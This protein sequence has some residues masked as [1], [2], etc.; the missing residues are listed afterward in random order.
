MCGVNVRPPVTPTPPPA[1]PPPSTPPPDQ[2]RPAPPVAAQPPAQPPVVAQPPDQDRPA[3]LG[4]TPSTN[5]CVDPAA[6]QQKLLEGL[7]GVA[8]M[9]LGA[10]ML[11]GGATPGATCCACVPPPPVQPQGGLQVG[12]VPGFPE[13]A[14]RTQGGYT[15]VPEGKDEAWRIYGPNQQFGDDA[16]TRVWGD[17]HVHEGDGTK[18]DFTKDSNFRLPDGTVIRADTT[19]EVGQS[20]TKGLTIVSGN[21]RVDI[22]GINANKPVVSG[23]QKDGQQYLR[24]NAATLQAGHTFQLQHEGKTVEWFRSTNGQQDGL[25]TG[26]RSNVDGKGSYDQIVDAKRR[27][28]AQPPQAQGLSSTPG[29][30][31]QLDMDKALSLFGL[32]ALGGMGFLGGGREVQGFFQQVSTALS[33]LLQQSE[34]SGLFQQNLA[35]TVRA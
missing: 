24:D 16:L 8:L 32:F 15:I 28:G 2:D 23:V 34:L 13:N 3:P 7:A 21:D 11:Q 27:P 35:R 4:G 14:V 29:Q 26:A 9:A 33:S 12:G 25:V 18:W 17:P 20:Y 19:S 1:A 5:P 22:T 6:L 30:T 10:R 31:A